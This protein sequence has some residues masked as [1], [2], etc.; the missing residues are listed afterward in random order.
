MQ[1]INAF[2]PQQPLLGDKDNAT[3]P[4]I[5][6]SGIFIV[7]SKFKQPYSLIDRNILPATI[8]LLIGVYFSEILVK[9]TSQ[10]I[11]ECVSTQKSP[12]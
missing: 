4:G 11:S 1:N 2:L 7:P 5:P 10:E 9:T 8:D 3:R 12:V 6:G